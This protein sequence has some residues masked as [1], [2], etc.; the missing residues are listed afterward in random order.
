[1]LFRSIGVRADRNCSCPA[2]TE[3]TRSGQRL[4]AQLARRSSR[5][6]RLPRGGSVGPWCAGS[7]VSPSFGGICEQPDRSGVKRYRKETGRNF[8]GDKAQREATA[9]PVGSLMPSF[10]AVARLPAA[11]GRPCAAT[12]MRLLPGVCTCMGTGDPAWL[13][14]QQ[15]DPAAA[16][17]LAQFASW[18]IAAGSLAQRHFI[19]VRRTATLHT[20]GRL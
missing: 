11:R 18:A 9:E 8:A 6:V 10:P 13:R 3:R 2:L 12:G 20:S 17:S 4:R 7:S 14:R 16:R 15:K 1:M 19:V 5:L